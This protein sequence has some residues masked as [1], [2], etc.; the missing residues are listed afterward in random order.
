[1]NLRRQFRLLPADETFLNEYGSPWETV[2]DRSQW[3]ILH[4]FKTHR[5]YG[6]N[7]VSIAIRMPTGYPRAQL[8]MV[9]VYPVL[10]RRDGHTIGCTQTRQSLDSK[11]WQRWSRH[12]TS[13]NPWN[14]QEDTLETHIYLI[15]DWF[16]REFEKCP[17]KALA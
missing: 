16:V 6:H 9:Y 1:M 10:N 8:D 14:P 3:V 17:E 2:V 13:A 12:R 4:N 7:S 11:Q 5:G 15:E